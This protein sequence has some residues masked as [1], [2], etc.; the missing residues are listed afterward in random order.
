MGIKYDRNGRA[1]C[2]ECGLSIHGDGVCDPHA[3]LV[4]RVRRIVAKGLAGRVPAVHT[5]EAIVKEL[6]L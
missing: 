3:V 2:Y 5:A 6:G 4:E 1:L